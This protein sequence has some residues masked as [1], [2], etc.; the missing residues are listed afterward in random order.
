MELIEKKFEAM[1]AGVKIDTSDKVDRIRVNVEEKDNVAEFSITLADDMELIVVDHRPD[2][3]HLLLMAKSSD[4]YG[5]K[6]YDEKIKFLCG[7]DERHWFS[8]QVPR[9]TKDVADAKEKLMPT[10]V[11]RIAKRK[12]V[13]DVTKRKTEAY[14]RQG[15]W[16]FIPSELTLVKDAVIVR[17]EPLSVSNTRSKPHMAE[18]CYR[19]GGVSVFVPQIPLHVSRSMDPEERK[20]LGAG[21]RYKEKAAFIKQFKEAKNWTWRVSRV[22]AMVYVRGNV[23]HPDHATINLKGWHRVYLNEE[24]R[25]R[26]NVFLD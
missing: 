18:E 24:V 23:R 19:S 2:D 7:H 8:S 9:G 12:G 6:M 5:Q 13:K 17:N 14:V 15:E 11:R 10:V 3:R 21:L 4:P 16:F 20:R 1:G 22:N 26:F 25:G